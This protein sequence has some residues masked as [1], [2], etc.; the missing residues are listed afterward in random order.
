MKLEEVAMLAG[1]GEE[2][3]FVKYFDGTTGKELPW[4]AVEASTRT[5][6]EVSG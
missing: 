6:V 3:E 5:R 2:D 1:A 4:Q